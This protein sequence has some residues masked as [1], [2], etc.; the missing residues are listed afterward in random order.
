MSVSYKANKTVSV[1]GI[2]NVDPDY[3]NG[4]IPYSLDNVDVFR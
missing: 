1:G 4:E 2:L 3:A